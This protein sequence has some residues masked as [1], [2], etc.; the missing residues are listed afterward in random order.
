MGAGSYAIYR[1]TAQGDAGYIIGAND[2]T[3]WNDTTA[4]INKVYWYGIIARGS[5][6]C[7][8]LSAQDSGYI[9]VTPPPVAPPDAPLNFDAMIIS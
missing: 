4:L 1:S 8:V 9:N 2:D 5:G 7:S 6:N 3:T